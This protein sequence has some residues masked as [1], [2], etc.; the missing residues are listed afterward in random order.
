MTNKK[1]PVEGFYGLGIA[2]KLLEILDKKKFT[3]PTPIQHEA[4]PIGISGKDMIGIAQTGTGKTLA[5]GIPMIQRLATGNHQGVVLVPTRELAL[6]VDEQIQAIGRDLGLHTAVLIGGA[7]IEAQKKLLRRNP[8]IIVATPGRFIDHMNQ[9]SLHLNDV[10]TLV[11][12]EADR[13]LDMGF[14]PQI[15]KILEA[16]PKVRQTLLFSATM[17]TDIVKIAEKHMQMPVRVEMARPGTTAENV[18]QEMFIV[19]KDDKNRLLEVMLERYQGT[20]LVFSRT[21]HG[22]T[23][24]CRAIKRMGHTAAEI[25]SDKSLSQRKEALLGFK[26]GKYRILVAT[27]IAARGID[28][29]GIELVINYDLPDS[30][31]DY[32]HRIGRTGRAGAKGRAIS[33]AAPD[34]RFKVRIIER[35]VNSQ[36][37]T[38]PLPEL[39]PHREP[40]FR[41]D[42]MEDRGS[43]GGFGR[44]RQGGDRRP[45][46]RSNERSGGFSQRRPL[47]ETRGE[48]RMASTAP[49]RRTA[50]VAPSTIPAEERS[51]RERVMASGNRADRRKSLQRGAG[52][53]RG[54]G[55]SSHGRMFGKKPRTGSGRSER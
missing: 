34:Q 31:E 51:P 16:L 49:V 11:L 32:V 30:P 37:G 43:R 20:V 38:S 21:R 8:H 18:T 14:A 42:E 47:F 9:R 22:A 29:T 50:G 53:P 28:V 39:P 46:G 54:R 33:F 35:L 25:H 5:F 45:F 6:Q 40:A 19:K 41:E 24:I 4:I 12:D 48:S 55:A 27:D 7:S 17:P 3:V 15:N 10:N 44:G 2:P 23:K 13:M 1:T 26:M 36:I 52:K